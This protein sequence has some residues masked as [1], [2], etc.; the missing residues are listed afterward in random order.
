MRTL[1]DEVEIIGLVGRDG[2]RPRLGNLRHVRDVA[3]EHRAL[4]AFCQRQLRGRKLKGSEVDRKGKKHAVVSRYCCGSCVGQVLA[5]QARQ[6]DKAERK[7]ATRLN[8]HPEKLPSRGD[9][10]RNKQPGRHWCARCT[11]SMA[12]S[13]S[14]R[15]YDQAQKDTERTDC[16]LV[17]MMG[18][19]AAA[20]M[21]T[22]L[23]LPSSWAEPFVE[24]YTS[25][26]W[27]LCTSASTPVAATWACCQTG[28]GESHGWPHSADAQ[29]TLTAN[30]VRLL[31]QL[32][33]H[34]VEAPATDTRVR[35]APCKHLEGLCGG[36]IVEGE[37]NVALACD[38]HVADLRSQVVRH[39]R[40]MC[41]GGGS[42]GWIRTT[43]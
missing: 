5:E 10:G 13:A 32:S 24:V 25:R 42:V 2:A 22:L 7:S 15:R 27:G 37:G 20:L 31:L 30:A 26:F 11:L 39:L 4:P 1:L 36:D 14:K 35:W 34:R 43:S 18:W 28:W 12:D 41:C 33:L 17:R 40:E 21:Y 16:A 6:A 19:L 8:V 38:C 9:A 29:N 23:S 3:D